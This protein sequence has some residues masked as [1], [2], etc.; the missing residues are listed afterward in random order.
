MAVRVARIPGQ[1]QEVCD[2]SDWGPLVSTNPLKL[3]ADRKLLDGF[4]GWL[5]VSTLRNRIQRGERL[6]MPDEAGVYAVVLPSLG[7]GRFEDETSAGRYQGRNPRVSRQ[8][9]QTA[10]VPNTQVV[11]VG[12][13]GRRGGGRHLEKRIEDLVRFGQGEDGVPHYGGKRLW[14]LS[15]REN[16]L[17]GWKVT[18][19]STG[20]EVR[21]QGQF[22]ARHRM[23]PFANEREEHADPPSTARFVSKDES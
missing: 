9:L 1:I 15:E 16:L 21:L 13:T 3:E 20:E 6:G 7:D 18:E 8:E 5:A 17:V 4:E 12:R 2:S 10:W 22:K 19:N 14:H 23:L 11:Y